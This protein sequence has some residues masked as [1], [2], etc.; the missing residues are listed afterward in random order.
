MYRFRFYHFL[1][2][3]AVSILFAPFV[4]AANIY[5][6]E[7]LT[8][9]DDIQNHFV[10]QKFIPTDDLISG[11]DVRF[12]P[13]Q[14]TTTIQV[15]LCHL[16]LTNATMAHAYRW[17]DNAAYLIASTTCQVSS[18]PDSTCDFGHKYPITPG[19][20]YFLM[21]NHNNYTSQHIHFDGEIVTNPYANGGV[22]GSD[23]T[24]G[25]YAMDNDLYFRTYYDPDDTYRYDPEGDT[26]VTIYDLPENDV[27]VSVGSKDYLTIHSRYCYI[28]ESCNLQVTYNWSAIGDVVRLFTDPLGTG[29]SGEFIASTTLLDQSI[30]KVDLPLTIATTTGDYYYCLESLNREIMYCE[31]LVKWIKAD[32]VDEYDS[33]TACDDMDQTA[34][35]TIWWNIQCA[36]RKTLYWAITPHT[37]DYLEFENTVSRFKENFPFSIIHDVKEIF[38]EVD[39]VSVEPLSVPLIW[40]L[41]DQELT[42]EN[43]IIAEY[44]ITTTTVMTILDEDFYDRGR[45]FFILIIYLILFGIIVKETIYWINHL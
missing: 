1:A 11:V 30:L 17:C 28:N 42:E 22:V 20:K 34:S 21:F 9:G 2:A 40:W 37:S 13:G 3:L 14:A 38:R 19:D 7:Q 35:S 41:P 25:T 6:Q 29:E 32:I 12:Y 26:D 24:V 31:I 36:L 45:T 33:E 44:E 27:T 4:Q 43:I 18:S 5:D 39:Q 8:T 10:G 23:T 16:E 15:R